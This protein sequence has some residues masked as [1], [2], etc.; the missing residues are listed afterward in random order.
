MRCKTVCERAQDLS[1]RL[2]RNRDAVIGGHDHADSPVDMIAEA[3]AD[4]R[5]AA[6]EALGV[7]GSDACRGCAEGRITLYALKGGCIACRTKE[8]EK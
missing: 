7:W 2:N 6:L 1:D 8:V 5:D 4:E 3:L